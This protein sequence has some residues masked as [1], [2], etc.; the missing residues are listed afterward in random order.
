MNPFEMMTRPVTPL[1]SRTPSAG[2]ER[3]DPN[4]YP[5]GCSAGR[6]YEY[7]RRTYEIMSRLLAMGISGRKIAE[8]LNVK[9]DAVRNMQRRIYRGGPAYDP[10]GK[11]PE[12]LK[13]D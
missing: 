13:K 12:Q 11:F 2:K 7:P 5:Q 8:Q 10:K 4:K 3:V 9:Y 1:K 6:P